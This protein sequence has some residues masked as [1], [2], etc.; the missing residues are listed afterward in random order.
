VKRIMVSGMPVEVPTTV[1]EREHYRSRIKQLEQERILEERHRYEKN[2]PLESYDVPS[3]CEH[4][5]CGYR[6]TFVCAVAVQPFLE[7]RSVGELRFYCDK[8][9]SEHVDTPNT[10][11]LSL[12]EDFT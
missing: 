3:S 10:G 1:P 6:A 9:M 2:V 5:G 4:E 8:H 12:W 7:K 11:A